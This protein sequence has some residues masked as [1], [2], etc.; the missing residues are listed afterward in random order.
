MDSIRL[1]ELVQNVYRGFQRKQS[2]CVT[3]VF[4]IQICAVL[5]NTKPVLDILFVFWLL[6]LGTFVLIHVAHRYASNRFLILGASEAAEKGDLAG[7]LYALRLGSICN[8]RTM[9]IAAKGG[10]L[11]IV[12]QLREQF[13]CPWDAVACESAASGGHEAVLDYLL[14][15]GSVLQ[16]TMNE[17]ARQ[18][19]KT[20]I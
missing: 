13:D 14:Q 7:T 15:K 10:H 18:R 12:Q 6:F 8:A 11:D 9:T 16:H 2:S 17:P 4:S 3:I 20:T 19:L 1:L 5:L